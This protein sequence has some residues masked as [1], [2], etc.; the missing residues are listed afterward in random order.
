MA[1]ELSRTEKEIFCAE[2]P[3]LCRNPERT[4]G[5]YHDG[6]VTFS[7]GLGFSVMM[8]VKTDNSI[9]FYDVSKE[10]PDGVREDLPAPPGFIDTLLAQAKKV[11]SYIKT[12][13]I[14]IAIIV[15]GLFLVQILGVFKK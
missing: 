15:V 11:F 13:L 1:R 7:N 10:Y 6:V 4:K 9:L 3:D 5:L 8:F 2:R 14:L 12:I